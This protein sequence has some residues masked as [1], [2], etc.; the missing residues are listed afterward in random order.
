M[1]LV[2]QCNHKVMIGGMQGVESEKKGHRSRGCRL[3]TYR[4]SYLI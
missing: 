4:P 2:A 3:L 1:I